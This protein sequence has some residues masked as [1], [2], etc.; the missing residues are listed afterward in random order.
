MAN[1]AAGE[2]QVTPEN[3]KMLRDNLASLMQLISKG[4]E[5]PFNTN[6]E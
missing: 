4:S 1:E 5:D 6:K 2:I 3:K